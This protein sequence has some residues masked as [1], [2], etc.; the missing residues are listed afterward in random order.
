MKSEGFCSFC[1]EK[2]SGSAMSRHLESC[3]ERKKKIGQ[4]KGNEKACLIKASCEPFWVY[5]EAGSGSTLEDIDSFL[6]DLWL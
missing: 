3:P 2:F 5:F 6:R 4:E 1:R